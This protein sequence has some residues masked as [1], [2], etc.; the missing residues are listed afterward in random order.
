MSAIASGL[1]LDREVEQGASG[2]A[3]LFDFRRPT[4]YP[5]EAVRNFAALHE[6]FARDMA[7]G[8]RAD[9]RTIVTFEEVAVE[10]VT[11]EDLIMSLPNPS[12]VVTF[13]I[14]SGVFLVD[15]D[16]ELAL[17][18][19][20]RLLGGGTG[21]VVE[22][23][24]LTAVEIELLTHLLR[25]IVTG[26]AEALNPLTPTQPRLVGIEFNPQLV[27]VAAPSDRVVMLT[28]ELIAGQGGLTRGLVNLSYLSSTVQPLLDRMAWVADPAD[29]PQ[30]PLLTESLRDI[31]VTVRATLRPSQVAAPVVAGLQVGDVLTLDHRVDEPV[32]VTV[33]GRHVFDAHIGRRG[34]RVAVQI[35]A[36]HD[37]TPP[38]KA[39]PA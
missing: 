36:V 24:R 29:S 10:Q 1:D 17:L 28:Y 2:G 20:D 9:L 39:E 27:Q 34:P 37:P 4:G 16:I 33:E 18:L 31:D 15:L 38:R 19:I 26:V 25:H 22:S 30:S 6:L 8:W 5:R 7:R 3:Q 14:E 13:A 23:R 11:F 35:S 21:M 12:V 32:A